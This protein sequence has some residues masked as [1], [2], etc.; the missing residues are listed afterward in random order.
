MYNMRLGRPGHISAEPYQ[1]QSSLNF[2][3]HKPSLISPRW[4]I[5]QY[6]LRCNTHSHK[7]LAIEERP[8]EASGRL[9]HLYPSVEWEVYRKIRT[10]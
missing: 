3:M 2:H 10:S 7:C 1:G 4:L 9:I 8:L 6:S 5:H